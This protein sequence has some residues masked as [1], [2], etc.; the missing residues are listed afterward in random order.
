MGSSVKHP[1][2]IGTVL[3]RLFS[4][5][6]IAG[7][8]K[9]QQ[10]ILAWNDVVGPVIAKVTEP[11][12]IEHGRLYVEVENNTWRQELHFYKHQIV[13]KLNNELKSKIV[14]EIILV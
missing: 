4:N 11:V 7:G 5:L 1:E 10:A 13:E 12:R 2:A 3:N 14:K 6:G 9:Q 8:I